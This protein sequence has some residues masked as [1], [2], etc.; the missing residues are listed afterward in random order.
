MQH[1]FL[2]E[3]YS[4]QV[5]MHYPNIRRLMQDFDDPVTGMRRQQPLPGHLQAILDIPDS[6]DQTAQRAPSRKVSSS[7]HKITLTDPVLA[8]VTFVNSQV[9]LLPFRTTLLILPS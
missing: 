1:T 5:E 2:Q 9:M 6:D 4:G 3:K 8:A 7:V